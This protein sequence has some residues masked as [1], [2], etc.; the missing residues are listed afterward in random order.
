MKPQDAQLCY[1]KSESEGIYKPATKQ[2][3]LSPP[4]LPAPTPSHCA[5]RC[6]PFTQGSQVF[7]RAL[8]CLQTITLSLTC[9]PSHPRQPDSIPSL[10][11]HTHIPHHSAACDLAKPK[12]GPTISWVPHTRHRPLLTLEVGPSHL[13]STAIWGTPVF[14]RSQRGG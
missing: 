11:F 5:I 8:Q 3:Q 7:S 9:S 14:P 4:P 13:H 10:L 2:Q 6:T 12:Q 1:P